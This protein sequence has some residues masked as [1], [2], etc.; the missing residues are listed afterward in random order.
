MKFEKKRYLPVLLILLLFAAGSRIGAVSAKYVTE[1]T[2]Q[3]QVTFTAKLAEKMVLEE[4]EVVRT[5]KGDYAYE[6][7]PD[8]NHYIT[9]KSNS[10]VLMPGVDIVKKPYIQISQKTP[11][12]AYLFLEIVGHQPG[13]ETNGVKYTLED[14][15]QPAMTGEGATQTQFTGKNQGLVYVY[16]SDGN[17]VELD[18]NL[19]QD[20]G[21]K[22]IDI[23]KEGK[24]YV[25]QKLDKSAEAFTVTFYAVMAEAVEGKS[26]AQ[27]YNDAVT[28]PQNTP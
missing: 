25:S 3:S 12:K 15:W 8:T 19:T 2:L 9:V 17:P 7:Q 11:I 5:P 24:V 27:T 22:N 16:S 6:T 13:A 20:T 10:Y 14:E 21:F 1:R 23:I 28:L 18:E 4:Y 26:L